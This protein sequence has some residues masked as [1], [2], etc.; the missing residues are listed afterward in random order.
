M[1]FSALLT[2]LMASAAMA[3]PQGDMT[4]NTMGA[5]EKRASFPIPASKG[6]VTYKSAQAVKG[7]F[8][9]GMKTYGRGVKCTG[10]AEGGDK[11]AVFILENGATLKNVIIGADQIEGVHCKG[12]CTIENVWWKKVCEDALSLKGNGN[13]LVKGGGATGAED[14]IIQH[15]GLGT[16]TIDG[17]TAVDFGKL[18]RSCGN[19][20][21]MGTRNV[22]VKNVKAYN[23][24][25][26]TGINSNKGD[27]ATIT[28]TCASS[29]KEICTE[30]QGTTPGNEPKKLR[31]GP[32][33]AC[34]YS[35]L[36]SC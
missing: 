25:L 9:G 18:Y 13:A 28:N 5:L 31:S 16:V 19:C 12:S 11:D 34:K 15:N 36:K 32:S 3:M 26:L 22:V 2:G 33:S 30:F 14:K 23:G 24:K 6:S 17:F 20:K 10:Q 4:P 27:I 35:T 8:D 21:T 29:V 7:T 1:K